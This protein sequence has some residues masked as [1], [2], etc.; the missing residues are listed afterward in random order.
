MTTLKYTKHG[1]QRANQRGL[2]RKDIELIHRCGTPV[3]DRQCEVYLLRNKDVEREIKE[4]KQEIQT[5][6]R[7]RGCEAVIVG[8][9]I[10]TAHHTSRRH[11]KKLLQ[12]AG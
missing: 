11:R 6:E 12:R 4:R 7:L 8:D 5:L 3:H 1:E 2:H 9:K 10:V